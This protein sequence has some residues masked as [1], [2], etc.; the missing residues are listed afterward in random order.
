[1]TYKKAC[2]L[3]GKNSLFDNGAGKIGHLL[4]KE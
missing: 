3:W 4:V 2:A 1:M